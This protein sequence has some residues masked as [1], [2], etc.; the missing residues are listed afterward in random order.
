MLLLPSNMAHPLPNPTQNFSELTSQIQ[1]LTE[2]I[3]QEEQIIRQRRD[4]ACLYGYSST[5]KLCDEIGDVAQFFFNPIGSIIDAIHGEKY[6]DSTQRFHDDNTEIEKELAIIQSE[7]DHYYN[8]TLL[9]PIHSSFLSVYSTEK[10]PPPTTTVK[11]YT[12]KKTLWYDYLLYL[13][14]K[15]QALT[16]QLAALKAEDEKFITDFRKFTGKQPAWFTHK[17]TKRQSKSAIQKS[18]SPISTFLTIKQT[19]PLFFPFT[20]ILTIFTH[21]Q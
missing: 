6:K 17:I 18:I 5:P 10:P 8:K 20:A 1:N 9:L 2:L 7:I 11:P 3:S 12:K 15:K 21:F 16:T 13:R 4:I 14:Y 19:S